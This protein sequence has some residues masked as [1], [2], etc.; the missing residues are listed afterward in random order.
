MKAIRVTCTWTILCKK[1]K[2]NSMKGSRPFF[3]FIGVSDELWV[4]MACA[5]LT[6]SRYYSLIPGNRSSGHELW[7]FGDSSWLRQNMPSVDMDDV[8]KPSIY[9][10]GGHPVSGCFKDVLDIVWGM[11]EKVAGTMNESDYKSVIQNAC[12]GAGACGGMYKIQWP[13]LL[14]HSGMAMPYN[15]SNWQ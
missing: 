9:T 5:I 13:Q 12:P 1:S 4:R 8:P 14:R 2:R 6:I 3:T 7:R 10:S 11:G 15:S